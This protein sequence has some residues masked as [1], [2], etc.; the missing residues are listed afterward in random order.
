MRHIHIRDKLSELNINLEDLALGDFDYIGEFT[1]KKQREASHPYFKTHGCFFRPNYER[2]ILIY[3]LIRKYNLTSM[4]EIGFGRGYGTMCAAKAFHDMGIEG[5]I[6]TIDPNLDEDFVR[7]LTQVFPKSWFSMIQFA[8]GT[9]NNVLPQVKENFDMIYIDGDHTY[10]GVK[11]DWNNCK[12]KFNKFL[13]FD[14]YHLPTKNDPGIQCAKAIDEID[15]PKDL[16]IMDRRIFHDDL[17]REDKEVD[18]GQVLI[19]REG[20]ALHSMPK[21]Q[22]PFSEVWSP[23]DNVPEADSELMS[24]RNEWMDE[25]EDVD[26]IFP[27]SI[28]MG[29]LESSLVNR[30]KSWPKRG[31]SYIKL[32]NSLSD[33]SADL[34]SKSDSSNIDVDKITSLSSNMDDP[35]FIFGNM[36]AGTSLL[37]CLLDGHNSLLALPVDSH[38]MKHHSPEATVPS[39]TMINEARSR[40]L[41][42]LISP[43]G[44]SPYLLLGKD[45]GAYQKFTDAYEW[46]SMNLLDEAPF[47]LFKVAASAFALSYPHKLNK[48]F[49]VVEK[50]P[51]NERFFSQI[52][53]NFT[54]AS[55]VHVLRNPIDNVAS[56]KK[57][58]ESRDES[59]NLRHVAHSINTGLELAIDNSASSEQ[60]KLVKYEDLVENT[61]DVMREVSKHV[62]ISYTKSLLKPTSLKLSNKSN[63]M[64]DSRRV[65]GEICVE[66]K[67]E[68]QN[69]INSTLTDSEISEVIRICGE[70]AKKLGYTLDS[71]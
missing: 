20:D 63:S 52:S 48:D 18:Y 26:A 44:Y 15:A 49:R 25:D 9:S 31:E 32:M 43:T 36:K 55:Y 56:M 27:S 71:A 29:A 38:L 62:G 46:A 34:V 7:N 70:N 59:F 37:L 35:V 30:E 47:S 24:Y 23:E 39:R 53:K 1:A 8:K 2:G 50:T 28:T 64:F 14:D 69:R 66:E 5:K 11:S 6:V 45:R 58:C 22:S 12:D 3:S 51:E 13:L 60:Y 57:L 68:R 17:C 16:I 65:T 33:F 42:K 21:N 54:N 41:G 61:E 67:E 40:W 19:E 4:L 10:E